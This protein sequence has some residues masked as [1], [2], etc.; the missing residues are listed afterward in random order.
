MHISLDVWNTL[1]KPNTQTYPKVRAELISKWCGVS[2]EDAAMLYRNAKRMLDERARWLGISSTVE[3]NWTMLVD[4]ITLWAKERDPKFKMANIVSD[5]HIIR[6]ALARDC[7][8]A[9]LQHRPTILPETVQ[10][11]RDLQNQG[12]S[13]CITSNTNFI[14]GSTVLKVLHEGGIN[15]HRINCRFSDSERTS[16]P[17]RDIFKEILTDKGLHGREFDYLLDHVVHIG[18]DPHCDNARGVVPHRIID[19]VHELPGVL[20]EYLK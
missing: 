20:A 17:H 2:V 5:P 18:D 9:F 8:E 11:I 12:H 19:G 13:F 6:I 7:H 1:L 16:K 15:I 10:I 3:Y 4:M 14:S